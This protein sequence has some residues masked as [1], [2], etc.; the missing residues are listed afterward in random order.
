MVKRY[1]IR[2]F[3]MPIET[4]F[5]SRLLAG[6]DGLSFEQIFPPGFYRRRYLA[7]IVEAVDS[8]FRCRL[9]R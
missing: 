5:R 6:T 2:R 9:R 7:R 3:L 1:A 4:V 8:H